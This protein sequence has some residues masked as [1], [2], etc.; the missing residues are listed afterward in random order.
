MA[1]NPQYTDFR[2]PFD[3]LADLH[4]LGLERIYKNQFARGDRSA[5]EG[6]G[7]ARSGVGRTSSPNYN[8]GVNAPSSQWQAREGSGRVL[9]PAVQMNYSRD[10]GNSNVRGGEER[11]LVKG[12]EQY[13]N[14]W[15]RYKQDI[16]KLRKSQ[17]EKAD[18]EATTRAEEER[19]AQYAPQMERLGQ[20]ESEM[21]DVEAQ[22]EA[23]SNRIAMTKGIQDFRDTQ[24]QAQARDVQASNMGSFQSSAQNIPTASKPSLPKGSPIGM[25]SDL[26]QESARAQMENIFADIQ[27]SKPRSSGVTPMDFSK[28]RYG[29][30]PGQTSPFPPFNKSQNTSSLSG[31]PATPPAPPPP[32][33]GYNPSQG[34]PPGPKSMHRRRPR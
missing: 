13:G 20:L 18:E 10:Y 9:P 32:P 30:P 27:P 24:R 5:I 28:M 15:N 26:D 16:G 19:T 21:A 1:Q 12:I 11:R 23:V 31:Q 33:M 29:I 4:N 17:R 25:L 6:G 8:L 7:G 34:A 3:L 22:K 2:D 14:I